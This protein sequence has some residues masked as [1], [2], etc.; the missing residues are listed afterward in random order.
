[1]YRF[2][3]ACM[4][5]VF[6]AALPIGRDNNARALDLD[7]DAI[8]RCTAE[9]AGL[10][11]SC[12]DARGLIMTNSTVCHSFVRIVKQQFKPEGWDSLLV[13][14]VGGGRVPNLNPEQVKAIREYLV[15]TFNADHPPPDLPLDWTSY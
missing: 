13:R 11:K 5:L 9:D 10:V 7:L 1:M 6:M 2:W 15:A 14:H 8:F 4:S 3:L 12:R